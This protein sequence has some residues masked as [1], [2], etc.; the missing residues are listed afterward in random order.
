MALPNE[1]SARWMGPVTEAQR[2]QLRQRKCD[3]AR[4]MRKTSPGPG[5]DHG[6]NG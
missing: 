3:T 4:E 2:P 1:Q 6:Y 5:V